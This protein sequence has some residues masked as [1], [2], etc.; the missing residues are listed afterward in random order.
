MNFLFHALLA[1]LA[2]CGIYAAATLLVWKLK[3]FLMFPA[4][5]SS[6]DNAQIFL[7]LPTGE[8]IAV[9]WLPSP[10]DGSSVILYS[11]GNG[12]DLGNISG[13]LEEFSSR[14]FSVCGYDYVGYGASRGKPV[15]EKIYLAADAVWD[16]LVNDKGIAPN[17]IA[18][19]G[20]SI[21]SA[22]ATHL[23]AKHPN[24][25]CLVLCGGFVD[26]IR[27]VLPFKAFPLKILDNASRL[28]QIRLPMLVLHG[29]KDRIVPP[30]NAPKIVELAKNA[31]SKR[32]VWLKG[33]GHFCSEAENY[34]DE[35][36]SFINTAD[37]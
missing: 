35:V 3:N 9:F 21:G 11:H 7:P 13:L 29:T 4:P 33:T 26:G 6:Y 37:R 1:I 18:I 28:E 34:F 5:E 32:L 8:K 25:R 16:W 31:P 30:R 27:V 22:A 23:A 17:R 19:V 2:L 20:Y 12:E 15:E 24:A 36:T 14:G 10:A